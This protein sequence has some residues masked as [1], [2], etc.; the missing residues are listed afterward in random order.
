MSVETAACSSSD[1]PAESHL[2]AMSAGGSS[3]SFL[4][5]EPNV[6]QT[7]MSF[8]LS[9]SADPSVGICFFAQGAT[10]PSLSASQIHRPTPVPA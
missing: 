5:Q 6:L 4:A 8:H 9:S 10:L 7:N 1:D 2:R 3:S